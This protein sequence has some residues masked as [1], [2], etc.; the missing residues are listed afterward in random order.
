MFLQCLL[1]NPK[2]L[3]AFCS[4]LLSPFPYLFI[5]MSVS[6]SIPSAYKVFHFIYPGFTPDSLLVHLWFCP[7]L[8]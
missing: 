6:L 5:S 3:S 7:R 2:D 8:T 1:I 4:L